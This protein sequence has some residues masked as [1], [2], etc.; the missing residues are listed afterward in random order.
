[1]RKF[2]NLSE[3]DWN[4]YQH[5]ADPE[6]VSSHY[7]SMRYVFYPAICWNVLDILCLYYSSRTVAFG[8][9]GGRYMYDTKYHQAILNLHKCWDFLIIIRIQDITLHIYGAYFYINFHN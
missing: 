7:I 5:G 3:L 8:G 1:M 6:P 9:L 4:P 2:Q